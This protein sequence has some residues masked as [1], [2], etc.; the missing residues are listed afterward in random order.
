MGIALQ[1]LDG[2]H[3]QA[4]ADVSARLER[5][6]ADGWALAGAAETGSVGRIANLCEERVDRGVYRLAIDSDGYFASLGMSG[7]YPEIIIVFRIHDESGTCQINVSLS[8]HSF[9]VHFVTMPSRAGG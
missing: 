4:A 5:A 2:T 9:S 6:C 3:G 8:P 1:I 7:A